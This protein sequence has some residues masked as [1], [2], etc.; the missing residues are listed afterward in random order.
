[1]NAK[2]IADQI[3]TL[4]QIYLEKYQA[5]NNM[6]PELA[7]KFVVER[8]LNM[9]KDQPQ[10]LEQLLDEEIEDAIRAKAAA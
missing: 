9:Y 4:T 5:A 8:I 6:H 1:M 3:K 10:W 7:A 2:K